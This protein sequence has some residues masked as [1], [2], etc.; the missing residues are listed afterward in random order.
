MSGPFQR[1]PLLVLAGGHSRR[2][3]RDKATIRWEGRPLLLRVIERLA[4]LSESV[5]VSA[6]PDQDLPP[7]DYLRVDDRRPGE[8]PLAGLA[9]GL[10]VAGR[11]NARR[12]VLVSACDYPFADPALYR[13]LLDAATD[14][15]AV[16]PRVAGRSHPLAAV[17]RADAA[18]ACERCLARGERRVRA[19]L[20]ALDAREIDMDGRE[21]FDAERALLNVN[22]PGALERAR[23][24][25]S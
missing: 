10:R 9:E 3:G 18:A 19:A 1:L 5:V 25:K 2:M 7:G 17:W 6:R 14:A 13:A 24:E 20:E 23:R 21:D 16:V 12:S 15:S 4:P 11:E 22:D 8:G